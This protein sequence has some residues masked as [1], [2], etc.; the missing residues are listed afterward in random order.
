ME[1][2]NEKRIWDTL[3]GAIGNPYGV[4]GI[5]GNLMAES[6]LNPRCK[7]GGNKMVDGEQYTNSVNQGYISGEVFAHDGVAYGLVQWCYWSRKERLYKFLQRES[8]YADIGDLD[9]QLEYILDEMP[10]YKT[11]WNTILNATS[12]KEASDMVMLRYEQPG[13]TSDKAKE[14]RAQFGQEFFDKYAKDTA[15]KGLDILPDPALPRVR[16]IKSGVNIRFGNSKKYGVITQIAKAGTTFPYVT[17]IGDW[18]AVEVVV[19]HKRYVGWVLRDFT[20][21]V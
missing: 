4:A 11:V 1:M 14:K 18:Y 9:F 10:T 7:T 3:M 12:V 13:N 6:S 17:T 15:P 5:M 19:N 2:Q 20:E 8:R 16:T 21:V